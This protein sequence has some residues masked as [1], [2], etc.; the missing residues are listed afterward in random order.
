MM[1]KTIKTSKIVVLLHTPAG[2]L[3]AGNRS[4]IYKQPG[5]QTVF[6]FWAIF[7]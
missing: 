2:M 7:K 5:P 3:E 1:K 6:K 4:H